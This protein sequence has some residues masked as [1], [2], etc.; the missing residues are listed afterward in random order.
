MFILF[1][2]LWAVNN[3]ID[4]LQTKHDSLQGNM[5]FFLTDICMA[6]EPHLI[7]CGKLPGN[8]ELPILLLFLLTITFIVLFLLCILRS[9]NGLVNATVRHPISVSSY[10][11]VAVFRLCWGPMMVWWMSQSTS[12]SV[13][14]QLMPQMEQHRGQ[15]A[16]LVPLYVYIY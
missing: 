14:P 3:G 7:I 5:S 8:Q 10:H 11:S 9:D 15:S 2:S 13:C 6:Y 12:S 16:A 1:T 4:Q